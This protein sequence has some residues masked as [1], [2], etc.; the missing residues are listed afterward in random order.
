MD[1]AVPVLLQP[2]LEDYLSALKPLYPAFYG[3]YIYGSLALNAFEE[4]ESDIDMVALT[5]EAL[6][7]A[8]LGQIESIHQRLA[9]ENPYG[10]RL[11]PLYIPF[12]HSGKVNAE[13]APY[14]YAADGRFF[15]SGYFDLNA[16]TWW[17]I[18]ERGICLLGPDRAT[19]PLETSWQDVLQAMRYNLDGYWSGKARRPYHFLINYWVMTATA[20]LCRILTA[21]EESE[22]ISKT[23]AL[24]RWRDRLP[25][26]WQRLID[27][28]LRLRLHT[29]SPAFYRTRFKR[30]QETLAFIEYARAR[31]HKTLDLLPGE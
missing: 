10:K 9:S 30:M 13:I 22:I 26:R 31:G 2:L 8:E 23:E 14:P 6:T 5:R 12:Q 19:L 11:A 3:I 18:K 16:V 1:R 21:I 4:P 25:V 24:Q 20:T 29:S 7:E 28:A 27:E 15:R 17:L